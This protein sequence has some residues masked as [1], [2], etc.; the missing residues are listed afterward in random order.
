M[1]DIDLPQ[2]W[3]SRF[4][5]ALAPLFEAREIDD[6]AFHHVLLDGGY[7]TFALSTSVEK[8]WHQPEVAGWAWS[9]DL[10]HHVTVTTNEVAVLRWDRPSEPRIFSRSSVERSLD[11]FYAYLVKDRLR[12]TN[13]VV[14]HFLSFFRRVRSL[15]YAAGIPDHRATDVFLAALSRLIW[16]GKER[17]NPKVFGLADDIDRLEAKLDLKAMTSAEEEMRRASGSQ[18]PLKLFPS[19]AIRHAGGLLFQEAHFELLR[20]SSSVD[21]F[22]VVGTAE[23]RKATRGGAHFTPPALARILVEQVLKEISDVDSRPTLTICDPACGS[24]AFLHEVLRALRRKSFSGRVT[25]VGQDI[26]SAAI[27]MARFAIGASLADWSPLGGYQ[28]TLDVGDSLG[29]KGIPAADVIVMN[30]PFVGFGDQTSEQ[31][32][33][34]RRTVGTGGAARGDLSMAF[35]LRSL[36]ALKPGGVL[37]TIFPASL[38][39]LGA[40]ASWRGELASSG[41]IRF[42]GSI[43]DFGLFAHALVQVACAVVK[44]APPRDSGELTALVTGNDAQATGEAFR[45]LRRM[46]HEASAPSRIDSDWRVFHVPTRG[47]KDRATW[48]FASPRVEHALNALQG[49]HLSTIGGLFEVKQGVQTGLNAALLLT[50][51]EWKKLPSRERRYFRLATMSDSIKNGKVES[52]Y[53]LFFPHERTGPLFKNEAAMRTAV[54]SYYKAFLEPNRARLANRASI[55]RAKRSD[56]WGLMH[57]REWSFETQPKIISKFFA[58]QGGFAGDY[59]AAY[60][61]VMGHAWFARESLAE[62]TGIGLSLEDIL[63]AYIALFNSVLFLKLVESFS[64]HVS[65]GQF[66]LSLRYVANIPTPNLSGL[67]LSIEGGRLVHELSALGHAINL[68]D[69]GWL[70]RNADVV[71]RL[72]GSRFANI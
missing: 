19:L 21:L 46:D 38:L 69:R 54:P 37:G 12:S 18:S 16:S 2:L 49:P 64:P 65:G 29:E 36:A 11:G 4:G 15:N 30:P 56:W 60:L 59:E 42:L 27:A 5:L 55:V 66:D 53:F 13:T 72:Y 47:L 57:A 61:P 58:S 48:R 14:D 50:R 25:I 26:S 31:R 71:S 67:S 40:A 52:P 1:T 17:Y 3:S 63:A 45:W 6:P 33:Q 7:G 24:G 22:G 41:D 10:P 9:G 8:L 68:G 39:S 28:L 20:A 43:G 35:V 62:N 51:E 34:L 23:A 70:S 32:E 44:K